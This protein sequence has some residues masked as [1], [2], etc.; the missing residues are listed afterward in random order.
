[1]SLF[2]NCLRLEG[3]HS[4]TSVT[5]FGQK[6]RHSPPTLPTSSNDYFII[7]RS[8]GL[9]EDRLQ[10]HGVPSVLPLCH[11]F[12]HAVHSRSYARSSCLTGHPNTAAGKTNASIS[13][14]HHKR[15]FQSTT[16]CYSKTYLGL[17]YIGWLLINPQLQDFKD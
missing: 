7:T 2:L 14:F 16:F 4:W 15:S 13:L 11:L 12:Q 6:Q 5:K 17:I 10:H 8:R 9:A 3:R 1:M